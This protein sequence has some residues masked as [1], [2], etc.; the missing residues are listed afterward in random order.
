MRC[1]ALSISRLTEVLSKNDYKANFV[2]FKMIKNGVRS[3]S[4]LKMANFTKVRLWREERSHLAREYWFKTTCKWRVGFLE[5]PMEFREWLHLTV[6]LKENIHL[7]ALT[8]LLSSLTFGLTAH[9]FFLGNFVVINST[10]MDTFAC[11]IC[12]I[13]IWVISWT[14]CCAALSLGS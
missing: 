6:F 1:W 2:I 12:A 4:N 8:G 9:R 5:K 3:L 14:I 7:A 10:V 11:S 13:N